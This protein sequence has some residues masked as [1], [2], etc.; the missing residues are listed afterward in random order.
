MDDDISM[1]EERK[2]QDE[3]KRGTGG[4]SIWTREEEP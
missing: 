3:Y 1:E 2:N 4:H